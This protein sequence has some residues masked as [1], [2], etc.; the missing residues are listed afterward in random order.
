MAIYN[1]G[2][3]TNRC[4][5]SRVKLAYVNLRLYV[6]TIKYQYFTVACS[7]IRAYLFSCL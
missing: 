7:D 1:L 2:V 6:S 3:T 5:L 4:N